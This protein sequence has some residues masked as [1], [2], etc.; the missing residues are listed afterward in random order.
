MFYNILEHIHELRIKNRR[1]Q[2]LT[3]CISNFIEKRSSILDVGCG[4]GELA[5]TVA[6]KISCTRVKGIDVLERDSCQLDYKTFDGI[7]IPYANN[8]FDYILLIDVLH[9]TN[10]PKDLLKECSRVS[11]KGIILKDHTCNTKM[12]SRILRFMDQ[13]GNDRFDVHLPH[14]YLSTDQW[15]KLFKNLN[16]EAFYFEPNFK[17]YPYPFSI[18]FDRKLHFICHLTQLS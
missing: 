1:V 9:H 8:S 6:T 7:H 3:S 13:V 10:H 17:L 18:I 4:D 11:K 5:C 12:D 2:I 16:L 14:N 15:T